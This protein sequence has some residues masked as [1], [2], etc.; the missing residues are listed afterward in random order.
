MG[1]KLWL[2]IVLALFIRNIV[3]IF[4]LKNRDNVNLESE[5]LDGSNLDR[6]D[7]R[8]LRENL[9]YGWICGFIILKFPESSIKILTIKFYLIK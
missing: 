7:Q 2:I 4:K 1:H 5:S 9:T 6:Y 8:F 3:K